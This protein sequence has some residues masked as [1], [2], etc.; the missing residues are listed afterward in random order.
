MIGIIQ[1]VGIYTYI[2]Y[3]V[4]TWI[5]SSNHIIIIISELVATIFS[6]SSS[7]FLWLT[8]EHR[9][10]QRE[11][12]PFFSHPCFLLF[13]FFFFFSLSFCMSYSLLLLLLLPP[14]L[15]YYIQQWLLFQSKL[16]FYT[17]ISC[18]FFSFC[19]VGFCQ[20]SGE[21]E[22]ELTQSSRLRFLAMSLFLLPISFMSSNG[23]WNLIFSSSSFLS[24]RQNEKTEKKKEKLLP[25]SLP[26]KKREDVWRPFCHC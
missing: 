16:F 23:R 22:K 2:V 9:T 26:A 11:L 6:C 15:C 7:S 3:Y 24:Q 10:K 17:N 14:W 19:D 5:G 12:F 8:A 21:E 1:R 18:S 4:Y 25:V 13:F 20:N